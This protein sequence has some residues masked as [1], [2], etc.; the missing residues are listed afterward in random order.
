MFS[1]RANVDAEGG[2]GGGFGGE[3]GGACGCGGLLSGVMVR[4]PCT[5]SLTTPFLLH[6]LARGTFR[7]TGEARSRSV[8]LV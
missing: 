3:D 5:L 7:R 2:G 6:T 8:L 4:R 1:I